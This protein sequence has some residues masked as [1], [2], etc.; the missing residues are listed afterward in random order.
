MRTAKGYCHNNK[1]GTAR[2]VCASDRM[3]TVE[4]VIKVYKIDTNVW[5]VEKF[6]V[7]PH[8]GY[9]KDRKVRWIVKNGTVVDGE[10]NDTGK[11]LV[12]P[13]FGFEL[14]LVKRKNVVDV[15]KIV[16]DMWKDARKYAP[17]QHT[18]PKFKKTSNM[19]E[20]IL[21][22]Y[23]FGGLAWHEETG[24]DY[25][26]KIAAKNL[27]R[28]VASLIVRSSCMKYEQVILPIVGDYFNSDHEQNTTTKGTFQ[29]EDT[30]WQKTFRFGRQVAVETIEMLSE[31]APVKVFVIRGNHDD[32]RSY[33]LGDSLSCW[34]HNSRR[35]TIDNLAYPRKYMHWGKVLL[36]FAHGDK[37]RHY[38]LPMLMAEEA[39]HA[40]VETEHREWHIGHIH[41][42]RIEMFEGG[43]TVVKAYRALTRKSA[44]TVDSGYTAKV[45]A[46][47]NMWSKDEGWLGCFNAHP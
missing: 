14:T 24:H 16:S 19:L 29:D 25:D 34:Y 5:E 4:E 22:D 7:K 18:Y 15:S 10:V 1:K 44:W 21:A 38:T 40:W 43:S 8:E 31:I 13:L 3:M 27:E 39:K 2:V 45:S 28:V 20:I 23:H 26:I 41:Q 36:G 35:V 6:K 42:K 47:A 33:Y 17:K 32:Q 12:V 30:R 9:R 11:M 46:E 37:E